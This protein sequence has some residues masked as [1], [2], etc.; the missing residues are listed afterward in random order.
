[1]RRDV[2]HADDL[3]ARPVTAR[4]ATEAGRA[5]AARYMTQTGTTVSIGRNTGALDPVTYEPVPTVLYTGPARVQTYEPVQLATEVGGGSA[6]VQRYAVHVPVG[7]YVPEID[8]IVTVTACA[9]DANLAGRVFKVR[10]LLHKSAATAYR[11][12]V[13]D[14]NGFGG[15]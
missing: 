5:L 3:G 6:T 2:D 9:L 13:D 8:D 1:M 7:S 11:L 15:A 14:T 12:V 4:S 10:G